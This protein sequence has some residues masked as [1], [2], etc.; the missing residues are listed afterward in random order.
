MIPD[1]RPEITLDQFQDTTLYQFL[2]LGGN[3]SDDYGLARLALFY[4][5]ES[6][7]DPSETSPKYQAYDLPLDRKQNNQSYYHQWKVDTLQLKPGDK[8]RYYLKVWDNDAINGYKSAKTAAYVFQ[9]PDKQV[10]KDNLDKSSAETQ[11]QISKTVQQAEQ[12][13][14]SVDDLEKKLRGKKEL[15][16][17]DKEKLEDI[18]KQ[19]E[20]L[21][22]QLK[23]LQ[24]QNESMNQQ[25]EQFDEQSEKHAE[26][27]QSTA[28]PHG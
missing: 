20:A 24:E 25:R 14:E 21:E 11:S 17:Q 28:K 2:V 8:I 7:D 9:V 12:L 1:Q 26:A 15:N 3:V 19:R 22:K 18:L 10:I 13:E 27:N 23:E 4:R 5:F 16:W 6:A